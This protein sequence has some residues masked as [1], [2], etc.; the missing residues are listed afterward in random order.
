MQKLFKLTTAFGLMA[1][2]SFTAV[3]E[4]SYKPSSND[5]CIVARKQMEK[6][7]AQYF[8]SQDPNKLASCRKDSECSWI[9]G[10]IWQ[11]ATPMNK[12]A[13]AEYELL[14]GD[15]NYT[16]LEEIENSNCEPTMHIMVAFPDPTG[17]YCDQQVNRCVLEFNN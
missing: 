16:R 8:S 7:T 15:P 12:R 9:R 13:V 1:G 11:P 5:Y 4:R 3:A 14:Q 17:A 6:I 2:F 10:P